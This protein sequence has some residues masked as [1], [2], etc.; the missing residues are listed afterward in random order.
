M[1]DEKLKS[2]RILTAL[3]IALIFI[4]GI[5]ATFSI[6]NL[7]WN[8]R[9]TLHTKDVLRLSD[10][11]YNAVLQSESGLRGY[12]LSRDQSF[13]KDFSNGKI[14]SSKLLDSLEELTV[15]NFSQQRNF[16]ILRSVIKERMNLLDGIFATVGGSM[17]Q[18][19]SSV[20]DQVIQGKVLT[21]RI[22]Q[23]INDIILTE[24]AL[25]YERNLGLTRYLNLLPAIL[26]FTTIIGFGAGALSLYSIYRYNKSKKDADRR[27]ADYQDQLKEQIVRLNISNQELEQFAY[28]ASHDLQEPLRKISAFG[29]LLNDQYNEKLEG[30]GTLYLDRII[31]SS[32]RMRSLITD[33]LNYSRVTRK[34]V[35][36]TVDL[37]IVLQMVREDLEILIGDKNAEITGQ[38]LL[39][40]RGNISEY[41]QLF[42]N[43]ISNSLK[44]ASPERKPAIRISSLP[45]SNEDLNRV[46][47]FIQN[48]KYIS[49]TFED[50]GIG[51]EEEYAQK[52]FVI[53]QRLHARE[54][55]EGTGI[56]LA[57]CKKIAEKYN[58][59]IYAKSVPGKSA[60]FTVI[61]PAA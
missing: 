11:L 42:Q 30:D 60:T 39:R 57:V 8:V 43:L 24:E 19:D 25:L 61:L 49:V 15:D 1:R 52:I 28:V 33:L 32:R 48:Q 16:A 44:F 18:I 54:Q 41:R 7:N 21:Q 50:N 47:S 14:T 51:F 2:I 59:A 9:W 23:R 10:E 22:R 56:G 58:G 53:F 5:I 35:L 20:A 29:E 13:V 55:F 17:T 37:N 45:A 4:T 34:T 27:I 31:G 3:S 6:R 46:P 40:V 26:I 38:N 12:M 36:E